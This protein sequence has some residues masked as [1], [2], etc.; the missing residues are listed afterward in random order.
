MNLFTVLARWLLGAVF[1]YLGL[2]KALHPVE[3]LK[4]LREYDLTRD[5]LAP[6]RPGRGVALV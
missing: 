6:E 1:V 3:F 5:A 4:L 2:T